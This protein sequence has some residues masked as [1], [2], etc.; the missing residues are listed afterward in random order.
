MKFK[1]FLINYTVQGYNEKID[2]WINETIEE[3][4]RNIE[5]NAESF[6]SRAF[7]DKQT[8]MDWRH[9]DFNFTEKYQ[10]YI[11]SEIKN[12]SYNDIRRI[13][14]S[15]KNH[16]INIANRAQYLIIIMIFIPILISFI[17]SYTFQP[18]GLI[19]TILNVISIISAMIGIHERINLNSYNGMYQEMINLLEDEIKNK[20]K[21]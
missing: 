18:H 10:K 11:Q 8:F 3:R 14:L 19:N 17:A 13:I 2:F 5:N 6:I 4:Y 21:Q 16:N 7:N 1:E 20:D 9:N 15:L 12:W